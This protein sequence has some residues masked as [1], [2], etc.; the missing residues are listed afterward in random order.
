MSQAIYKF[1]NFVLQLLRG[2]TPW[3]DKARLTKIYISWTKCHR[4]TYKKKTHLYLHFATDHN[5]KWLYLA[6]LWDMNSGAMVFILNL[7][8][9]SL[10]KLFPTMNI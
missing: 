10:K 2:L 8:K 1:I 5:N 3:I 4:K 6:F 7:D 9:V